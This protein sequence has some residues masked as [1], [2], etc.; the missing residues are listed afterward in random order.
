MKSQL[1]AL[2]EQ[3]LASLSASL[4]RDVPFPAGLQ[5]DAA[6]DPRHGDFATNLALIAAKGLGQPPRAVAQALLEHLPASS[7][8]AKAEIAGPGF[9]NFFL[10]PGAFQ[11]VVSRVLEQGADYGCDRS[12][13]LGKV[14]VEFVSANPTGPMHVGHGRGAAYGDSLASILAVTGWTVHREYYINDAGRQVDI[15]TVSVWIRYLQARGVELPFPQRGYPADYIRLTADRLVREHGDALRRDATS[16]VATLQAEPPAAGDVDDKTKAAIKA[17]QESAMDELIEQSRAAL[18][19]DYAV[20][21]S[22]ALADQLAAIRATLDAFGVRFDQ[23]YSEQS[24]VD[25]GFARTAIDRLRTAGHV[26]EQ[27]GATWLRTTTFGDEKDRVLFKADGAATYFAND[28]AYH[29][30]KLDRGYPVLL[31]VWGADHHGYIARVRAAIEALTGRKDA[32]RVQLMQFVTLSSGRMGKRSGNFVTLQ[33]LISEAGKD[34]TRFFY[35]LRSHDQHLEFDIEL[36]RSQSNDNPVF[37]VQY[38]HARICSVFRQAAER[39]Q[40]FDI[41]ALA[42]SLHRLVEPQEKLLLTLMQ[43]YPETLNAAARQYA[44]HLLAFYLRELADALH[45]CYNAHKFLVDDAELQSARLGLVAATRQV[46]ANGLGLLGVSAPE[47]M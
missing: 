33:D 41:G 39:G 40:S 36:A 31:D 14:M 44:P 5:I 42:G 24:L 4:G 2:L 10:A 15:L 47:S 21:R 16:L 30:D 34:A 12:G 17:R 7:L 28:L 38:A 3:A 29:V 1:Q 20:V 37:Y 13:A 18:G 26:Y 46:L 43:K 35:L 6:K 22:A 25:S 8:I 27:D 23:W 19:T 9:I 32:L 45:S 11:S